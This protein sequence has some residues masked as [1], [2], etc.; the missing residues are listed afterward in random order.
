ML[1]C[2]ISKV[3]GQSMTP[4]FFDL[5]YVLSMCWPNINYKLGDVVLVEHPRYGRIIKR[6]CHIGLHN[7]YLLS[8]DHASST[9]TKQLG[10]I[11]QV[12]ILGRVV[13]HVK[14]PRY[15]K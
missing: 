12:N 8:G 6:I 7:T 9:S 13:F 1:K 5:D 11:K 14:Q 4:T 2:N 10:L 15:I 3:R